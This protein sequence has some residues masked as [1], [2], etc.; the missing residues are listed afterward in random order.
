MWYGKQRRGWDEKLT[1]NF[2]GPYTEQNNIV[3]K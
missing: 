2:M 3:T 1:S